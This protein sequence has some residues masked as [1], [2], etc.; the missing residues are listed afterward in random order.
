MPKGVSW[1]N[2]DQKLHEFIM[3]NWLHLKK[4]S[5]LELIWNTSKYA[6]MGKADVADI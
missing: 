1:D 2:S 3:V 6:A 4:K 5:N